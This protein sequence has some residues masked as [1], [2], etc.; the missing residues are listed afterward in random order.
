MGLH[1]LLLNNLVWQ[2]QKVT[3]IFAFSRVLRIDCT[4][5]SWLTLFSVFSSGDAV[6]SEE[7]MPEKCGFGGACEAAG[8][9]PSSAFCTNYIKKAS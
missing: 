4:L 9:D 6:D 7:R 1:S 3:I 2:I 8:K 5:T